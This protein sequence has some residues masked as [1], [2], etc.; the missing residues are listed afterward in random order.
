VG[1]SKEGVGAWEGE[2]GDLAAGYLVGEIDLMEG[3]TSSEKLT[4]VLEVEGSNVQ[5]VILKP[6]W[7]SVMT[8]E[9]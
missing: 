6:L 5:E 2:M 8:I 9:D 4:E 1:V 3:A 7:N